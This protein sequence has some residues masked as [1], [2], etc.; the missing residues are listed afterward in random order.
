MALE[1]TGA[2]REGPCVEEKG[3]FTFGTESLAAWQK[4]PRPRALAHFGTSRTPCLK[5]TIAL[6]M[7][8]DSLAMRR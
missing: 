5:A 8:R 7:R 2:V 1:R 4:P 6:D 3:E